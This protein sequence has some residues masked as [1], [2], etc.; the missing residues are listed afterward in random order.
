MLFLRRVVSTLRNSLI[1]QIHHNHQGQDSCKFGSSKYVAPTTT[2]T[3]VTTTATENPDIVDL[4]E[5]IAT[6]A[7]GVNT[8]TKD[9]VESEI[10]L[11]MAQIVEQQAALL[12]A[13]QTKFEQL[14][15]ERIQEEAQLANAAQ[16]L[17]AQVMVLHESLKNVALKVQS[18]ADA[19]TGD[20][21]GDGDGNGNDSSG[22]GNGKC[23]PEIVADG[24]DLTL[25]AASGDVTIESQQCGSVS[26]CAMSQSIAAVAKAIAE[27]GDL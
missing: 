23:K 5:Q 12:A 13:Q 17:T 9:F 20:G 11:A 2:S 4:K 1:Y 22:C 25:S 19:G 24:S 26:V 14:N 27:L 3:S 16:E 21:D 8:A 15:A 10:A 7:K 18:V 6:L